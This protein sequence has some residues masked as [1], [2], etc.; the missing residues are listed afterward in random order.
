MSDFEKASIESKWQDLEMKVHLPAYHP[1]RA[2]TSWLRSAYL[3]FFSALGYRFIARREMKVV[4]DRI[5]NPELPKPAAFRLTRPEQSA[6]MLLCIE[7]P[8]AFRSYAMFYGHHV[9]FLPR[10][11][12][13]AL[14]ERLAAHPETQATLNARQYPWPSSGPMFLHDFAR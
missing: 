6:P 12:D 9:V 7:T 8:E 3:A 13:H 14:Y 1:G 4:L 2:S 10:Y 11:N 5:R